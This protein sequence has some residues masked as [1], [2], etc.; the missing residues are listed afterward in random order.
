MAAWLVR[1][2]AVCMVRLMAVCLVR[3]MA[4]CFRWNSSGWMLLTAMAIS[5]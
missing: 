3:L 1:P 4:V 5:Y 2:R